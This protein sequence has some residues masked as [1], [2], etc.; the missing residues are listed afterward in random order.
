MIS[1]VRLFN[2]EHDLALA[3]DSCHFDAPQSAKIFA[4]DFSYLPIWF[5]NPRDAVFVQNRND[6]WFKEMQERFPLLREI[7]T[8]SNYQ[9]CEKIQPWGWDKTISCTLT[10]Y[11]FQNV[12]ESKSLEFIREISHRQLSIEAT[13]DI[14]NLAN[15]RVPIATPAYLLTEDDIEHFV[16]KHPYAIFKAPWS[17]SG[18]G[19]V[20]SLGSLTE[21]LLNRIKN[22]AKKQGSVLAEPL[23]NVVQNFA[24]EFL[25]ENGRTFFSG[26]SW[27]FTDSHGAYEGNLLASDEYIESQLGTWVSR[28]DL[29][30][31]KAFYIDFFNQ[32][33]SHS[34]TG[35]L[36]VDM[37][38]YQQ[39]NDYCIHPCVEINIR[40][41]MGLFARL[42]Y[43]S[44][45]EKGK[46]GSYYVEYFPNSNEL[47]E[48]HKKKLEQTLTIREGRLQKG[49]LSLTPINEE[50]HYRATIEII[51]SKNPLRQN[52]YC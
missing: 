35:Y 4:R 27:F 51:D 44:F 7:S 34:Y 23:Y 17:G 39:D 47:V 18:K 46:F 32:K 48:N 19:I 37:F 16:E 25:C 11:G 6:E 3:S 24:M 36:G 12:L 40:M 14:N 49:Y 22:I 29:Q 5:S 50:T 10:K 31:I 1:T 21:N 28:D 42:F 13:K 52:R 20:R 43:D 38:V 9:N 15:L 8:I 41:T 2:P 33:I 26:Y 45:V 30:K